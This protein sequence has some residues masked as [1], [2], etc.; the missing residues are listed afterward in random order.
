[1]LDLVVTNV[2]MVL[3]ITQLST[4]VVSLPLKLLLFFVVD[5]WSLVVTRLIG[6]Y[7]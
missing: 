5:G 6:S 2:L 7:V 3:N 4:A 1:M